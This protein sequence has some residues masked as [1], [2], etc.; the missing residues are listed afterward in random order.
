VKQEL[1]DIDEDALKRAFASAGD[2]L[3]ACHEQGRAR[4]RGEGGDARVMMRVGEDGRLRY[5]YFEESTLGDRDTEKCVLDALGAAA[6]P[7]PRGGEAEVRH[8]LSLEEGPERA[9]EWQGEEPARA[10]ARSKKTSAEVHK[11]RA[12][13]AGAFRITA[14]VKTVVPKPAPRR[15]AAPVAQLVAV[16]VVPPGKPGEER[17]DCVAKALRELRLAPTGAPLSKVKF[18]VP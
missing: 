6:W 14:Y 8:E 5:A 4:V 17:A 7:K 16:G 12:G 15:K 1:G 2:A 18:V 10:L 9:P 3:R 13:V 11:C